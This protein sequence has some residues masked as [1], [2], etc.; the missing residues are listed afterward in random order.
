MPH[1]GRWWAKTISVPVCLSVCLSDCRFGYRKDSR[2]R[3]RV[4]D[5]GRV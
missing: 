5:A 3:E 2:A 1:S 4:H